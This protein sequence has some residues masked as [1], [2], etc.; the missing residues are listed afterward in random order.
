MLINFF[1]KYWLFSS[2][3]N[4]LVFTDL[5]GTNKLASNRYQPI[6]GLR[7]PVPGLGLRIGFFATFAKES[8][9]WTTSP[10]VPS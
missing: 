7:F 8:G 9:L 2:L 3:N 4:G 5:V 6:I 10:Y 1:N